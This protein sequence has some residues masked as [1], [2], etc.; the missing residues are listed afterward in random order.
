MRK[1]IY[2]KLAPIGPCVLFTIACSEK[3]ENGIKVEIPQSLNGNTEVENYNGDY[4]NTANN[5]V[6][7]SGNYF[8]TQI[9]PI[10]ASF[11]L[12][13]LDNVL[14]KGSVGVGGYFGFASYKW[15]YSAYGINW[16]YKYTNL[17]FGGRGSFHYPLID[18]FDTYTGLM[19]GFETISSKEFGT[20][21][22]GVTN[23]VS[24]GLRTQWYIGGRYYFTDNIAGMAEVGYGISFLNLGLAIKL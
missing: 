4:S 21:T 2:N 7:Y 17:I 23:D 8:S 6:R 5:T 14:D 9:P 12:G 10:S 20:S 11:E 1:I 15:E 13:I 22:L 16:G 18:N 24:S 19:L 3:N